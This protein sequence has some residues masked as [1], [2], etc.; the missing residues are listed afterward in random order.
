L[1]SKDKTITIIDGSGVIHDPAGLDRSELV[2]LAHARL[3]VSNFDSSKFSKEGYFV[4]V[5]S[6]DVVL[7][8]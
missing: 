6:N 5:D 8:S 2:R 7:P 3:M 4:S 1:L